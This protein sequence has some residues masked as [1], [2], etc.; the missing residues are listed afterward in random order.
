MSR[1]NKKL[2]L[3]AVFSEFLEQLDGQSESNRYKYQHRLS[4][5][6]AV[7]GRKIPG[8]V[9]ARDI[10]QWAAVIEK[11]RGYSDATQAGFRQAMKTFWNYCC[12][13]KYVSQSPAQHLHVGSFLSARE[14]LPPEQIVQKMTAVAENWVNSGEATLVR[15]GVFVLLSVFS[16]PRLGELCN[17]KKSEVEAAL[18]F[19]PDSAGIYRVTSTGK[20]KEVKIRFDE[21][22]AWALHEWLRLRP[23]AAVDCCFVGMRPSRTKLDAAYRHRPLSRTAA[24]EIYRQV[25]QCAG[26]ER[27]ILS[28]KFRHRLGDNLTKKHGAKIAA[29]ALNHK[30]WKTA[31]TAIA[32][33]HHPN[34]VDVS[35]AMA[36]DGV[37]YQE[38][39][40]QLF[41]IK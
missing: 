36:G 37:E 9:T 5:F 16:G 26:V 18:R 2:L 13:K 27:P 23:S 39:M 14:K 15:N 31:A 28:H 25:A 6:L 40:K 3:S 32:F 34:E 19:G 12:R 1:I 4:D 22:L 7:H 30:D 35:V 38:G 29:I 20:T 21:S 17:L 8:E 41:G 24:T 10:N 33:Y 11:N